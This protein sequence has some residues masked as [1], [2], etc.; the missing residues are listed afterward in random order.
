MVDETTVQFHLIW[1]IND[2]DTAT[3]SL[4]VI[5]GIPEKVSSVSIKSTLRDL[6]STSLSWETGNW[7]KVVG[8]YESIW[9]KFTKEEFEEMCVKEP[10]VRYND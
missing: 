6:L 10:N 4:K 7:D 5:E 9:H 3:T 2:Y 8:G 1:S